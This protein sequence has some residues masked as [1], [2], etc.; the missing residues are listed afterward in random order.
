MTE[1][2]PYTVPAGYTLDDGQSYW[3]GDRI[4]PEYRLPFT[5]FDPTSGGQ[6]LGRMKWAMELFPARKRKGCK[7]IGGIALWARQTRDPRYTKRIFYFPTHSEAMTARIRTNGVDLISCAWRLYFCDVHGHL[8]AEA[9]SRDEHSTLVVKTGSSIS[10][11]VYF[12]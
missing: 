11:E 9:Y 5:A 4:F 8:I 1:T 2:T 3:T 7:A 12:E 10:N 6:G